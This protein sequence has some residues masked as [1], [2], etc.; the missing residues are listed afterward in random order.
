MLESLSLPAPNTLLELMLDREAKTS[1]WL[2][3]DSLL[4][5]ETLYTHTAVCKKASCASRAMDVWY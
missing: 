4:C 5:E 1:P 2:E 3:S